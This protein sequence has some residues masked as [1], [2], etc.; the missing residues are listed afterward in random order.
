MGVKTATVQIPG[1][2]CA[3][4]NRNVKA[5]KHLEKRK[6]KQAEKRLA[7]KHYRILIGL[8]IFGCIY[9]YFIQPITI[10]RD[11]RYTI[12]IFWMPTLAGLIALGI[13]RRKFLI[14]AF[15]TAKGF[16]VRS[17]MV[18]IF[19]IEGIVVSYL[20]FGQIANIGWNTINQN[21]AKGNPVETINCELTKFFLG[22]KSNNGMYFKFHGRSEKIKTDY[23]TIKFYLDK[24]PDD[25][26]L[27]IKVQKGIWNHYLLKQWTIK[28][29]KTATNSRL[30]Q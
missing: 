3:I 5:E 7:K 20:I 16:A 11:S 29:I 15:V 14:D 18:F 2:S 17:F 10:G 22:R 13:Y 8:L 30:A 26:K 24:N 23:Q 21:V 25:Y 27:E 9:Y 6:F 12:Y 1:T 4:K 28:E 19:F